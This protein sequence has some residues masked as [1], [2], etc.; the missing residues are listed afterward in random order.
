MLMNTLIIAEKMSVAVSL[1]RFLKLEKSKDG[2]FQGN[3]YFI[4]WASGHL[5]E[6]Y[7]PDDYDKKLKRW[8]W[9]TLP[10]IP[11]V[12]KIKSKNHKQLDILLKLIKKKD[13][14]QLINACDS[15]REGELIFRYIYEYSQCQTPVKRLWLNALTQESIAESFKNLINQETLDPLFLAAKS[16]AEADWL[17]GINGSRS[18]TLK[19]KLLLPVGRVQTPTLAIIAKRDREIESF[20]PQTFYELFA[21][22]SADKGSY[23]G[24][25]QGPE[26]DRSFDKQRIEEIHTRIKNKQGTVKTYKETQEK[27]LAPLLFDLGALQKEANQRFGFSASRT[28]KIAQSLYETKKLITYP[29]TDS[30]YLPASY[31]KEIPAILKALKNSVYS[32]YLSPLGKAINLKTRIF[33]DGKVTDHHAIVPTSTEPV[34]STLNIYEQKVYDAIVRRFLAAFYEPDLYRKVY[35][36]TLVK[37]ELFTTS[38]KVMV[39]P[40]WSVVYDRIPGDT[41]IA[42]KLQKG[43]PVQ[44]TDSYIEE[45][46]TQPPPHYND[47]TLVSILETA[48]KLIDDEELKEALKDRGLGT[49]ATRAQIID[50][51]ILYGYIERESNLLKITPKGKEFVEVIEKEN[52]DLI[53]PDLTA[54]WEFR[55][56]LIE[57]EKETREVFMK[58]IKEFVMNMVEG[59][60]VSETSSSLTVTSRVT[61]GISCPL[62][63]KNIKENRLAYACEGYKEGCKMT[64]WKRSFGRTISSKEAEKLLENKKIGPIWFTSR[65]GKKYS[66][67]L[68][69]TENGVTLEFENKLTSKRGYR[70][71]NQRDKQTDTPDVK[72]GIKKEV[73]VENN[74]HNVGSRVQKPEVVP[75]KNL[76]KKRK[77]PVKKT[78]NKDAQTKKNTKTADTTKG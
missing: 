78:V 41:K 3:D 48:G 22:F 20:T 76:V 19:H 58:D 6:L 8:S 66:A 15:G 45:G 53:S 55:L 32:P 7:N 61:L 60:K 51:L 43:D 2:F 25:W 39:K 5:I 35:I 38:E 28:L 46:V 50:K 72:K 70:K 30:K 71:G 57:K 10:I 42:F 56:K 26:G 73:F 44:V 54:E 4:S 21:D 69:I 74:N 36:E 1:A 67:S 34:S 77:S 47:G 13:V 27:V 12:F 17:V 49:P 40:G 65:A 29:R 68:V 52:P 14:K 59:I 62:C 16:R 9:K 31:I 37:E 63:G 75:K 18:F 11:E 23:Q 24:K 33:N 64:I